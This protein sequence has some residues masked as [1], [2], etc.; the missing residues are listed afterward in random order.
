MDKF[1]EVQSTLAKSNEVFTTFRQEMEKMAK[2]IKK[3]E[4]ETTQWRNKWESNNH[5]L[6]HMAEEKTLR[7]GHFKAL[8]GKLELRREWSEEANEVGSCLL[9]GSDVTPR[10]V[11]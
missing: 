8:Q 9:G 1:E 5:A 3:L 2:K 7:D 10:S 4:K 11:P 6:L